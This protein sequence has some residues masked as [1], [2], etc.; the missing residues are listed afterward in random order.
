[1]V[2][3]YKHFNLLQNN[4]ASDNGLVQA[5]SQKPKPHRKVVVV[6]FDLRCSVFKVY[7]QDDDDA[8]SDDDESNS[9]S[10]S[11]ENAN[12]AQ[13][14]VDEEDDEA[15]WEKFQKKLNK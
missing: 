15:E 4:K 7:L 3:V 2:M 13:S 9:G 14:T 6:D 12:K 10:D 8:S 5:N 11:E 1:M